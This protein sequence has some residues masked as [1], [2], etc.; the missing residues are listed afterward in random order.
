[1][2]I[3]ARRPLAAL[4]IALVVSGTAAFVRRRR[5]LDKHPGPAGPVTVRFVGGQVLLSVVLGACG[6]S[7]LPGGPLF[8]SLALRVVFTAVTIL[9]VA[10]TVVSAARTVRFWH[11]DRRPLAARAHAAAIVCASAAL[12]WTAVGF[13]SPLAWRSSDRGI[14]RLAVRLRDAGVSVQ[15][16]LVAYDAIG[17]P[18]RA[19][20]VADPT[21][22]FLRPETRRRWQRVAAS[23]GP[24]GY[25]YTDFMVKV[26]GRLHRAG[27]PLVAG[28]DAMGLALVAP[29]SSLHRELELLVRAGLT[30]YEAIRAATAAPAS[31]LMRDRDFG[32]VT[33]GQRADLLLVDGN[34]LENVG[35]LRQ[36]NGVMARGRW[37]P[38]Q[39]LDAMVA[40][41]AQQ[42]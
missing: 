2:R 14:D 33:I 35:R 24:S 7:F 30:P 17:G 31:F 20:L 27:V 8:D 41:L 9:M 1:M 19:Q 13:W 37:Y 18:G 34:P 15:T 25:R 39:A 10:T 42:P 16:T 22:G 12:A 23:T 40:P 28:T 21:I 38:R 26:A 11:A 3:T 29:G 36:P 6:I 4:T 5:R 32:T